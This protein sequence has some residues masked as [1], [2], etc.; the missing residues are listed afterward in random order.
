M[1]AH[2]AAVL[3]RAC[4]ICGSEDNSCE[5]RD[6]QER[7]A[8][9]F[10]IDN[11]VSVATGSATLLPILPL[12]LLACIAS[13][14]HRATD[15]QRLLRLSRSLHRLHAD[16][17]FGEVGWC[18]VI[19]HLA[20]TVGPRDMTVLSSRRVLAAVPQ[21]RRLRLTVDK[22]HYDTADMLH[23]FTIVPH[24]RQLCV[25]QC[26]S[27]YT[28]TED[29]TIDIHA[30]LHALPRLTALHLCDIRVGIADLLAIAAHSALEHVC[31]DRLQPYRASRVTYLDKDWLEDKP[32]GGFL[33]P[34]HHTREGQGEGEGV[35]GRGGPRQAH[36]DKQ[37]EVRESEEEDGKQWPVRDGAAAAL[38]SDRDEVDV[39]MQR[40][41]TAL[42]RSQPTLRSVETRL[43]L[44]GAVR[45]RL[46]RPSLG[47]SFRRPLSLLHLY[48]RHTQLVHAVLLQQRQ[49]L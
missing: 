9:S 27:D 35:E 14:L 33:F 1:T 7:Q 41:W 13:Y 20:E 10:H 3:S 36:T 48:R 19:V 26:D 29:S 24:I 25:T 46:S 44:V 8:A 38:S 17:S 45:R 40:L 6:H 15:V 4:P 18:N 12:P 16:R 30:T 32:D 2:C 39:G 34:P 22:L 23:S 49:Q 31:I 43:V 11:V 47:A 42:H 37:P 28:N 5:P 21:L